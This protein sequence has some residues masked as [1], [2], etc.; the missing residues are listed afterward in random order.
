M[1]FSVEGVLP[2]PVDVL[3]PQ[4]VLATDSAPLLIHFMGATWLPR[5]AVATMKQPLMVAAVYLGAGSG[6]YA[7]PFANDTLL[8]A[9]L[10]DSLRTRIAQVTGAPRVTRVYLSG[11]SAGYGAIREIVRR[12]ANVP[13]V[14]GILLLDKIKGFNGKGSYNTHVRTLAHVFTAPSKVITAWCYTLAPQVLATFTQVEWIEWGLW[15]E[16]EKQLE[17]LDKITKPDN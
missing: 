8:F 10:L 16:D 11:F 9:R 3:I 13:R 12:P 15:E 17:L 4:R 1:N 2:K 14:D 5:H 6:V 7:R